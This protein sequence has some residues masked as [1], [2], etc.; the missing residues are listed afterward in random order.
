MKKEEDDQGI[1]LKVHTGKGEI[2]VQ[3]ILNRQQNNQLY[4]EDF[5][6]KIQK[7]N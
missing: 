4:K 7:M 2:P 1:M 3:E 6:V 5:E